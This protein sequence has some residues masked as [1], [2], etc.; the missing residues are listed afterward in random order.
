MFDFLLP[1]WSYN[2]RVLWKLWDVWL[3]DRNVLLEECLWRWQPLLALP[4]HLL[5]STLLHDVRGS[6]YLSPQPLSSL[7]WTLSMLPC[8]KRLKPWAEIKIYFTLPLSCILSNEK[9]GTNTHEWIH[10]GMS[11]FD[12]RHGSEPRLRCG[13]WSLGSRWK[14]L[15]SLDDPDHCLQ[16]VHVSGVV[17]KTLCP[18]NCQG[19][20]ESL[21]WV[22]FAY[23]LSG[24]A[25]L[26]NLTD[27]MKILNKACCKLFRVLRS[28]AKLFPEASDNIFLPE[29]AGLPPFLPGQI[30][31]LPGLTF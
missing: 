16:A 20:G 17:L 19:S 21:R 10:P 9:K 3:A 7:S 27:W 15:L 8:H 25:A 2:V 31:G 22:S 11:W 29:V 30:R 24:Q 23:C 18:F 12:S 14:C 4:C 26:C 5:L 13:L 28:H 6:S 1:N